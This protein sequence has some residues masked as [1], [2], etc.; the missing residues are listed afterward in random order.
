MNNVT[1]LVLLLC[2]AFAVCIGFAAVL[3]SCNNEHKTNFVIDRG[4]YRY[5]MLEE[6]QFN[7]LIKALEN[8][9]AQKGNNETSNR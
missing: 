9:A 5:V 8:I 4:D 1:H 7:R 6:E 3:D 2:V